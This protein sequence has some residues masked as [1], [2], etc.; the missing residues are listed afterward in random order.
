[1]HAVEIVGDRALPAGHDFL[2]VTSD[3]GEV[4]FFRESTLTASTL[5]Q[6]WAAYRACCE[7]RAVSLSSSR[8]G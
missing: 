2:L 3:E 1:M 7:G 5:E 8:F 6:S 4:I